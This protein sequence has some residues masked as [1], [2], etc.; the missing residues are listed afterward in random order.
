MQRLD[1]VCR[2]PI[3]AAED[4]TNSS[5]YVCVCVGRLIW[6]VRESLGS[7]LLNGNISRSE[8]N[9]QRC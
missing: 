7:V 8:A 3:N 2:L 1:R 6:R 5:V 4:R 9:E